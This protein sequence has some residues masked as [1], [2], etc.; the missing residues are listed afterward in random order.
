MIK[1]LGIFD[2]LT[3]LL[4][5][6]FATFHIDFLY[7]FIM[8]LAII[9]II[10]GAIFLISLDIAS[11]IDIVMGGIIVLSLFIAL[12]KLLVFFIAFFL[13]QKGIFSLVS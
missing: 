3:A 13:I 8:V 2:I 12:P 6:I 4:F 5:W 1:I 11:I 7:K 9:L 10:K